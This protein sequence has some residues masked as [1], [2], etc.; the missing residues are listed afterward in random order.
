MITLDEPVVVLVRD[1]VEHVAGRVIRVRDPN[2]RWIH[3]RHWQGGYSGW[4]LYETWS[5]LEELSELQGP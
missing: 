3:A 4:R 1:I 5:T 2:T